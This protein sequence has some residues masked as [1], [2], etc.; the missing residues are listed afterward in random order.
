MEKDIGFEL[1]LIIISGPVYPSGH[2]VFVRV[3]GLQ[4]GAGYLDTTWDSTQSSG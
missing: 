1:G 2:P 4:K 3:P